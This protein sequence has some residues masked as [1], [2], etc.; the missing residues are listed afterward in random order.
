MTSSSY[1]QYGQDEPALE[2]RADQLPI[3]TIEQQTATEGPVEEVLHALHSTGAKLIVGPRGCGKTH[4]M[5]FAWAKAVE[6]KEAPLAIYVSFNRYLRLEPLLR[7]K[8]DAL[9]IFHGWIISLCYLGLYEVIEE[10]LTRD[11]SLDDTE[12]W[13][14]YEESDLQSIVARVERGGTLT[15]E[16]KEQFD[17]MSVAM[18]KRDIDRIA[19]A[20]GRKRSVLLLDDAA[21]TLAPEF[22]PNF[23]DVFRAVKSS[24]IA[25]KASVYPGTTEYGPRF[26][27]AHE[28]E[29]V[30]VW[31]AADDPRYS[32]LMDDIGQKRLQT[33]SQIPQAIREYFKYAAFGIPRA[34]LMLLNE[35]QSEG[36]GT[37]QSRANAILENFV[38]NKEAEYLSLIKKVP[39]FETLI[40]TGLVFFNRICK[41]LVEEN[42]TL[43]LVGEK[44][45]YVGIQ[46]SAVRNVYSERMI[47]LLMEAGLLYGQTSSVSH[48]KERVYERFMP[49]LGALLNDRAFAA[50]ERGFSPVTIVER[51]RFPASKHPVRRSLSTLLGADEL[52]GLKFDLP[53][54]QNCGTA[55]VSE[56]SKHCHQCGAQL[57]DASA[58]ASCMEIELHTV[59]NLTQW[60]SNALRNKLKGVRTIGDFLAL[61]DPGTELR[62]IVHVGPRRAN[63]ITRTIEEF[64]EEFF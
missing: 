6:K 11:L 45:L 42:A 51:L 27:V 2:V 23:F 7:T 38:K 37:S 46:E 63:Q 24:T 5:R 43:N 33:S 32:A 50:G 47:S 17:A 8:Y 20:L 28:A 64:V 60:Q 12:L 54:C 62:T 14:E 44:Q 58:F 49:H 52:K 53:P 10:H 3:E 19:R 15:S 22:L 36:E 61:P 56:T 59:P 29:E 34:Y 48:G 39:K 35:F 41:E 21:L 13:L 26:N 40:K 9:D 57:A 1:P 55:R 4:L 16:L 31:V 30:H 25:P 18:L